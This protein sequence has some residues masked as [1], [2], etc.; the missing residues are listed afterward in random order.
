[1]TLIKLGFEDKDKKE[2]KKKILSLMAGGAAGAI[3][4]FA[5]API[6]T[7]KD[8]QKQ[9]Q[10]SNRNALTKLREAGLS[11]AGFKP[12]PEALGDVAKDIWNHEKKLSKKI[13]SFYKGTS[14]GALKVAPAMAISFLAYDTLKDKINQHYK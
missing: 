8:T 11:E 9:N 2:S 4:N 13:K 12:A 5:V 14:A 7:I 6:D 3:S 10:T 1:M